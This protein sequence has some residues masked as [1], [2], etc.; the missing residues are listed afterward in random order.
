MDIFLYSGDTQQERRVLNF[1][2]DRGIEE[3]NEEV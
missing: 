3:W 1:P 2:L